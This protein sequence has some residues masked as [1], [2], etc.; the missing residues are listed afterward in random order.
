MKEV[1][2][3]NLK[4][5]S[6]IFKKSDSNTTYF[7]YNNIHKIA[8]LGIIGSII[9]ENGYNYNSLFKDKQNK[10][11]DFYNSLKNLKVGIKPNANN[12]FTKKIQSFN[13]SVGYASKEDGNNLI[14]SEQWIEN[15]SWDIYILKDD[16]PQYKKLKEYLIDKKCEYIPYIG[17]NDHFANI[18]DVKILDASILNNVIKID[19][20]F[21]EIDY[22]IVDDMV[23][24]IYGFDTK[25]E[26]KYEYKEVLP[27]S[28]DSKIGYTDFKEFV[29][30]NNEIN[31]N[32]KSDI[33][34]IYE[35]DKDNIYFF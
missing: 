1:I 5:I 2:K 8:L 30:T 17:K 9:G 14:V 3:F 32:N 16:S 11:P 15:P 6:G 28:L 19:S 4:G 25:K 33:N 20:I 13:N 23:D 21:K 31:I 29:Y 18:N 27:I 35:I 10:L 7:T 22:T 26:I 34:D 12:I 24:I